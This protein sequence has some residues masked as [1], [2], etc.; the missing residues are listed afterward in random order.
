MNDKLQERIFEWAKVTFGEKLAYDMRERAL[1]FLEEALELV[2]V[3]GLTA[4]DVTEMLQ[5]V[6]ERGPGDL[7]QELGGVFTTV[8]SLAAAAGIELREVGMREVE[9]CESRT[10]KIRDKHSNKPDHLKGSD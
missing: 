3:C 1:R 6:F 2:Q 7:H 5:Y 10:D 9:R 8:H 4:T